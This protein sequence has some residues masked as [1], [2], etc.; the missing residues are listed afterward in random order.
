MKVRWS[1][2]ARDDLERI[3]HFMAARD[4]AR[5]E[6][7]VR[8]ILKAVAKLEDFP[9]VGRPGIA[10]QTRE[11]VVLGLP[12]VVIYDIVDRCI[13][14]LRVHDGRSDWWSKTS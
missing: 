8:Q 3:W 7:V 13:R 11:L 10:S 2:A 6:R 5:A 1:I 9:L 12:H 4:S 14:V